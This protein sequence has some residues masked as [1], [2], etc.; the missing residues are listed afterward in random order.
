MGNPF[1]VVWDDFTGGYYVGETDAKQ[2]RNT[3]TGT[4]VNTTTHDGSIVATNSIRQI[5]IGGSVADA[6]ISS[7][8]IWLDAG[9]GSG[10]YTTIVDAA[11]TS[12]YIVF[13]QY[14]RQAGVPPTY[15]FRLI[16]ISQSDPPETSKAPAGSPGQSIWGVG[17]TSWVSFT[18]SSLY[19]SN[20]VYDGSNLY[21]CWGT[22]LYRYAPGAWTSTTAT[23]PGGAL[24]ANLVIYKDR[25]IAFEDSESTFYF[26]DALNFM[27]WPTL[28]YIGVGTPQTSI[29]AIVPRYDDLLIIKTDSIYSLVGTLSVNASL[30][31]VSDGIY[32]QNYAPVDGPRNSSIY[33]RSN[34][35]FYIDKSTMPYETNIKYLYGQQS[36]VAAFYN[37]GRT[38]PQFSN[39][40]DLSG[41]F[42]DQLM[43]TFPQDSYGQLGFYCLLRFSSGRWMRMSSPQFTFYDPTPANKAEYIFKYLAINNATRPYN[44]FAPV[45]PQPILFAQIGAR[46]VGGT[47]GR[48]AVIS[49][50]FVYPEQTGAGTYDYDGWKSSTNTTNFD[51]L[52]APSSGTVVLSPIET[53]QLS[54]ITAVYVETGLD[55]DYNQWGDLN[56]TASMQVTSINQAVDD[57]PFNSTTYTAVSGT[58]STSLTSFGSPYAY[59]SILTV[60][61]YPSYIPEPTGRLNSNRVLRFKPDNAG[62]GYKHNVSITFSGYR[63]KRV[64]VEGETR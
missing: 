39:G 13:L 36:G 53:E 52:S 58:T 21:V 20:L 27:S 3:W 35:L 9:A 47:P 43:A 12:S 10:N 60:P 49:I 59:P 37:F 28:N 61:I 44:P 7:D 14:R 56:G 2:P 40:V 8:S 18:G 50:G 64:W 63:I 1:K 24:Y 42:N 16:Y 22:T 6:T 31:Q 26:S 17:A 19:P 30:R 33:S 57:V 11:V 48:Y 46:Y 25:M 4:N 29:S 41:S 45:W 23:I 62:Y 55:L 15:S 5:A 34:R 54:K 38:I 51:N 32:F